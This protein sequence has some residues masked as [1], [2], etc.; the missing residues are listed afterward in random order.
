MTLLKLA[1]QYK[2]DVET[3]IVCIKE[4][5]DNADEA[6]H[7]SEECIDDYETQIAHWEATLKTIQEVI[8]KAGVNGELIVAAVLNELEYGY[9]VEE[10]ESYG[11][12]TCQEIGT[13]IFRKIENEPTEG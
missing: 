4:V 6:V 11:R 9:G 10:L 3:R 13:L 8:E 5:W 2:N 7:L 12:P 1:E